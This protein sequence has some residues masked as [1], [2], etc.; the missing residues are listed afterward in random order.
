MH[1]YI[2]TPFVNKRSLT[3]FLSI[4]L[5][6]H[7]H[8]YTLFLQII[9]KHYTVYKQTFANNLSFHVPIYWRTYIYIYIYIYTILTN[10]AYTQVYTLYKQTFGNGK[11]LSV[12]LLD[13]RYHVGASHRAVC[14]YIGIHAYSSSYSYSFWTVAIT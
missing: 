14:S 1:T 6:T 11:E 4:H 13:C 2:H 3:I 9:H 7:G 12:F 10:H 5:Y 8:I